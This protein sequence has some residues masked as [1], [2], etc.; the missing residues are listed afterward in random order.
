MA[1]KLHVNDMVIILTGKDKGK[2]GCIISFKKKQYVIVKGINLVKKHNKPNPKN[3]SAGG[4]IIKEAYIHISNIAIL[5]I[6]TGKPDRIG[7]KISQGK[8]VRYLKSNNEII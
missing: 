6:K 8:K 7:F 5:N 4:I 3:S 2:K 1:S